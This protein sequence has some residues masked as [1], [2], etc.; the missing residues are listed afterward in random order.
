MSIKA[1]RI[2][3]LARIDAVLAEKCLTVN[4]STSQHVVLLVSSFS[5]GWLRSLVDA[6]NLVVDA[7]FTGDLTVTF[8]LSSST[9]DA[10]KAG[11]CWN[12]SLR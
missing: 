2:G 1:V 5:L 9:A 12:N 6:V 10:G 8:D 3:E 4:Q 11:L 7:S